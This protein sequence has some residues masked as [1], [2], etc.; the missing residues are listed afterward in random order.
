MHTGVRTEVQAPDGQGRPAQ[1]CTGDQA[2]LLLKQSLHCAWVGARTCPA[3]AS[4][5][6]ASDPAVSPLPWRVALFLLGSCFL[7]SGCVWGCCLRYPA[8]VLGW[9][10]G[11]LHRQILR[12]NLRRQLPVMRQKQAAR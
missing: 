1:A 6:L 5:I 9:W 8:G 2:G 10:G 12:Q 3:P 11:P 7:H 4:R